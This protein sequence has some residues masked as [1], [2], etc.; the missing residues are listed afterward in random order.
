MVYGYHAHSSSTHKQIFSPFLY[1]SHRKCSK[2]IV[3]FTA[4]ELKVPCM[5]VLLVTTELELPCMQVLSL[6]TELELPCMQIFTI[7]ISDPAPPF[8]NYSMSNV[9]GSFDFG[10]MGILTEP[11]KNL[12][13]SV[14]FTPLEQQF[15]AASLK[16]LDETGKLITTITIQG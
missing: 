1:S 5:Q 3:M 8:T 7:F 4:T 16:L 6:R 15:Y 11:G 13:M 9:D 14:W 12:T 10:R 2:S